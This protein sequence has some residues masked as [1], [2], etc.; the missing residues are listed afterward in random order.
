MLNNLKFRYSF[1]AFLSLLTVLTI[2]APILAS[3]A[4][5]NKSF[6]QDDLNYLWK[7]DKAG[8]NTFLQR[9]QTRLPKY[10]SYFQ[11]AAKDIDVHW[12]LIAAISYQESHWNPKAISN[13]GVRGMM[14]L[15][16]KTA[17]RNGYKEENSSR[18]QYF[19]GSEVFSKDNGQIPK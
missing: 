12:T 1:V 9:A 17:K 4:E 3:Y 19:R 14:M 5:E 11:E 10:E 13:T 6:L 18:R 8:F 16:Q 7:E 2:E 15:T